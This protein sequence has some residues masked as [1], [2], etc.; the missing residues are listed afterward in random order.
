MGL[1]SLFPLF[2]VKLSVLANNIVHKNKINQHK[3]NH[4]TVCIYYRT[5]VYISPPAYVIFYITK[6]SKGGC[7]NPLFNCSIVMN[8]HTLFNLLHV[9]NSLL[10]HS[11]NRQFECMTRNESDTVTHITYNNYE[12]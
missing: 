6:Y 5:I 12:L 7:A 3:T 2:S 10:L 9:Y 1:N 8:Q 11:T 4:E